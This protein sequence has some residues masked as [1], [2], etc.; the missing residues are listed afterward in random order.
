MIFLAQG[1]VLFWGRAKRSDE[2]ECGVQ[3]RA[4]AGLGFGGVQDAEQSALRLLRLLGFQGGAHSVLRSPI[5]AGASGPLG[6]GGVLVYRRAGR[7]WYE[8][9][10]YCWGKMGLPVGA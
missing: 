2:V 6:E 3:T 9:V 7:F 4:H 1:E 5:S 8:C 10:L